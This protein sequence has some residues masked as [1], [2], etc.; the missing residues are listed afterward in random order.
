MSTHAT[1]VGGTLMTPGY[2]LVLGLAGLGVL[3]IIYRFAAG[4]GAVTSLNDG[5]PWG[6]WIAYDVVTGTAIACG[7]YAI[8]L[9][10]YIFNKGHYHPLVRPAILTAA[11]GY[12]LAGLAVAI[13]VG[14]P[15]YLWKVPIE[16]G[17]W[18]VNSVLLEVAICI[19]AY[20][21]VLWIELSPAILEEWKKSGRDKLRAFAEKTL[22][23]VEKF[24]IFV[25]AL[26]VLLPTMHQS[27]LG[28]LMMIAGPRMHPLWYTPWLPLFFLV[29]S[30]GMGYAVI[31]FELTAG[32]KFF[33][34]PFERHYLASL[35]T[36]AATL[37]AGFVIFRISDLAARGS[38][39]Y[40]FEPTYHAL[41]FWIEMLL[42]LSPWLLRLFAG[43]ITEL[44]RLVGS[45]MLIIT[46]GAAYRFGV[47]LIGFQPGPGWV[48][49]PSLV[50]VVITV[51][52]VAAEAAAY[53]YVVR[54]F[55][56]LA[57]HP[58]THS[59]RIPAT[60]VAPA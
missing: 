11:L 59:T 6:I 34:R 49:F 22:P 41:F 53:I 2:K 27:S 16:I 9:L 31:A 21:V 60:A 43:R 8:A 42:F 47:F 12:T 17:N 28:S 20:I 39:R 15:W 3:A 54:K 37:S 45:G 50:E 7:G 14:R 40:A 48:Y 25:I 30:V 29:T 26:G 36:L 24:L 55:P 1:P 52:L 56:I 51:G 58:T 10:V 13:D 5:Y 18:N 46:A 44:Q 38:I 32:S 23:V 33:K 19:M 4:L 57:G 35:E